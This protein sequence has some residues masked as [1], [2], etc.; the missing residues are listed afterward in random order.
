MLVRAL[1]RQAMAASIHTGPECLRE[2]AAAGSER[3][4]TQV[5]LTAADTRPHSLRA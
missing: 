4:E 5:P 2:M 3:E 1:P